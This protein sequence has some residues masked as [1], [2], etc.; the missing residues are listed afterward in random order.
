VK[1][2]RLH[3][4][5][6]GRCFERGDNVLEYW[7][8]NCEGFAIVRGRARGRVTGVVVD[9]E[10]GRARAVLA[11]SGTR[12]KVR[13]VAAA[14]VAAVDPFEKVL[15]LERRVRPG[16]VTVTVGRVVGGASALTRAGAVRCRG[17]VEW[18]GP[19][20][21]AGG[22]ATAGAAGRASAVGAR[23]ARSAAAWLRP[24]AAAYGRASA[25]AA[26][27]GLSAAWAWWI[28]VAVPAGKS[29]W[30]SAERRATRRSSGSSS[31]GG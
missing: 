5:T 1:E 13:T 18:A 8:A 21:C 26:R 12:G 6:H 7:L 19:R 15:Y 30:A 3:G 10:V 20:V 4:R 2:A 29:L 24:R 22:R 28:R 14:R 9:P 11:R 17:G 23:R 31:A 25:S 27:C 16:S